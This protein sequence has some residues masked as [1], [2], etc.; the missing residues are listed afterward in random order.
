[1]C[2]VGYV[3]CLCLVCVCEGGN[4][5]SVFCVC[6]VLFVVCLRVVCVKFECQ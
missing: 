5:F 4:V 6:V 3:W 1:M 2:V